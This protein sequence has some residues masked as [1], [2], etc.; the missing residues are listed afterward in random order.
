MAVRSQ[1]ARYSSVKSAGL[2]DCYCQEG[3]FLINWRANHV[4]QQPGQCGSDRKKR[5]LFA[6]T[7]MATRAK[8]PY[9]I[10]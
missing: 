2:Q 7:C 4:T 10:L 3:P 9:E 1:P 8:G 6:K 5:L